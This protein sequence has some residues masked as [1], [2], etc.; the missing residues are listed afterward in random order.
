[1]PQGGQWAWGLVQAGPWAFALM[2]RPQA[3]AARLVMLVLLLVR[4]AQPRAAE[5]V[6][7]VLV[8]RS[9]CICQ[10]YGLP[11]MTY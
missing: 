2:L 6:L 8:T 7:L 10:S 11:P 3:R 1:M 4:Q 9:V 5:L